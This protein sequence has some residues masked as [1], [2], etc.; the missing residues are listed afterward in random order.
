MPCNLAIS[1]AKAHVSADHLRALL[2]P[3][4][5]QAVVLAYL[6]QQYAAR[7]PRVLRTTADTVVFQVGTCRIII[8]RG[9]ITVTEQGANRQMADALATEMGKLLS[10]LADHLFAQAVQQRLASVV[11]SAQQVAVDNEGVPQQA[12]ILTLTL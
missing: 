11:T 10:L 2:T 9:E 7:S 4:T 1:I 5:V 8:S 3:E 12:T 6:Q